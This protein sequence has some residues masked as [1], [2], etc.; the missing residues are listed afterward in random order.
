MQTFP[1]DSYLRKHNAKVAQA[2]HEADVKNFLREGRPPTVED[3]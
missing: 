1:P 2:L 3:W